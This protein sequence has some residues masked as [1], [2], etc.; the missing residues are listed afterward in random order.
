[1]FAARLTNLAIILALVV[2]LLGGWTRLMDAGLGCPDWPGC[3]GSLVLPKDV[4]KVEA[5]APMFGVDQVDMSKGWIEMIHRYAASTLGFVILIIAVLGLRKRNEADYPLKLSLSLLAV[6]I[7]QGAFGMW[8]VT[9]KL[10]PIVVTIHLL[11]G[12]T[13]L[14]LLVLL[15][16]SLRRYIDRAPVTRS[17]TSIRILFAALFFQLALGGWTSTNYAG[18]SCT[19]WIYCNDG[20]DTQY[21]F[22]TGLNPVMEIGHNYEG[23]LLS[24]EARAAIQVTHRL[25]A[26]LLSVVVLW[27]V[28]KNWSQVRLRPA[29][30]LLVGALSLQIM[31]GLLTVIYLV[32]LNLAIAH[33]GVAMLVLLASLNLNSRLRA[34][35]K[36]A[37]HGYAATT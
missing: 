15:R 14:S 6:V 35:P 20:Y 37:L 13:I 3:Y 31:I 9:L 11:G 8:T 26:L 7:A 12:L 28:F 29:L 23:G 30:A 2:I 36:E 5:V 25:G 24:L 1:M 21:D 4:S 27:V 32:P 16:Q 18:W 19:D 34:E 22:A 33:H 10:L 17:A